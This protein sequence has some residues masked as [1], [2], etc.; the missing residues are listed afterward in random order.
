[1]L[2][3]DLSG[4]SE[5][6]ETARL[7]LPSENVL[8]ITEVHSFPFVI[9]KIIHVSLILLATKMSPFL[10]SFV[11]DVATIGFFFRNSCLK[12]Q[13]RT[14]FCVT[15]KHFPHPKS[16]KCKHCVWE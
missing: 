13:S 2:V 7:L 6:R 5:F 9:K 8:G 10:S 14:V 4:L 11:C 15:V 16:T 1:M 12:L 3:S